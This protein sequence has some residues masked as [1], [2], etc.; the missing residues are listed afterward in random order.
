MIDR[1]EDIVGRYPL[2]K[3][4]TNSLIAGHPDWT[5]EQVADRINKE[6]DTP[7]ITAEEVAYWRARMVT[8]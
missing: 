1:Y 7:V 3:T 8:P 5:N 6:Y 2:P 4:I